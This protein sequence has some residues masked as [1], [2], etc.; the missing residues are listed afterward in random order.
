MLFE[1]LVNNPQVV[2]FILHTNVATPVCTAE[3]CN[4]FQ[5]FVAFVLTMHKRRLILAGNSQAT[6]LVVLTVN[7]HHEYQ[8]LK[9]TFSRSES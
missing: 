6:D 4:L 1:F 5:G 9:K 3:G 2:A 8:I 7:G